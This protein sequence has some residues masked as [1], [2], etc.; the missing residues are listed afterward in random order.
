MSLPNSG[1]GCQEAS[2][3]EQK[4]VKMCV[5]S[6]L[7]QTC[8]VLPSISCLCL[9]VAFTAVPNKAKVASKK[10]LNSEDDDDFDE[11]D[12]F[13]ASEDDMEDVRCV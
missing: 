9:R 1:G 12:D 13:L 2:G 7:F 5:Q 10:R 8:I 3:T 11:D 6:W 4:K